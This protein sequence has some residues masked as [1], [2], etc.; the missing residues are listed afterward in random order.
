MRGRDTSSA[1]PLREHPPAR[2]RL[3]DELLR[4]LSESPKRI[5]SMHLYDERGS[6]LF[7][8]ICTLP[9]YYLTRVETALLE[10]HGAEIARRLG[11]D[12]LLVELGSG[13]SRKTRLLFDRLERPAGYVPVDI[14]RE[15]LIAASRAM[16]E[17]YP[18]LEV[19]PVC[20][21]FTEPFAVPRPARAPARTAV[22]FPGSTIGN[23]DRE[24]A[25]ELLREIRRTAGTGGA[26]LIGIDLEK[27]PAVLERAY[28]DAQGVTAAFDLN[29]LRR[30]NREFGADFDLSAF[31]HRAPWVEAERRIEMHLVSRRA[32]TVH[33][34]GREIEIAAGEP[35]VTE[36]CHKYTVE[37]FAASAARAGWEIEA[38]WTDAAFPFAVVYLEV[39]S[40]GRRAV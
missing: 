3:L 15:P 25:L 31:R 11:P 10:R 27:D 4:G 40:A 32:Q 35:I 28:D 12:V 14:S 33:L 21:D 23:F 24:P 16:S 7:E 29:L 20:A 6:R 18:G 19:L 36:H 13:A 1:F 2:A 9:E 37:G 38:A 26:L 8:R 39:S 34:G 5:A 22:F 30:I 17:A